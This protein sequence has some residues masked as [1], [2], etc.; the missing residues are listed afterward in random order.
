M[1]DPSPDG[2]DVLLRVEA[3]ALNRLDIVQREGWYHMPGFTY[4]H[5]AGN[6]RRGH[7]RRCRAPTS[8]R[9]R[10][11]SGSSSTPRCPVCP[12]A[13]CSPARAISHGELAVIGA[14]ED[15]GYA[16]LCLVPAPPRHRVPDGMSIEHAADVPHVLA[17]SPLRALLTS[18]IS[19]LARQ[20]S[21]MPPA[22]VCR[23]QPIQLAK[24]AGATVLA[25]AGTDEKCQRALDTR[26]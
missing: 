16:E 25:T 20:S 9:S 26:S 7:G 2:M 19:E 12:S 21:S 6:G 22:R 8:P 23:S 14:T 17:H 4:P 3:C 24:R 11:A 15:G 5:I 1:P 18:A 13:R 10:W